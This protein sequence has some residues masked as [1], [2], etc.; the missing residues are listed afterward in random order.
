MRNIL[1]K[2]LGRKAKK[3]REI[4]VSLKGDVDNTGE[5]G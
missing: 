2:N 4:L 3:I 5:D 1:G